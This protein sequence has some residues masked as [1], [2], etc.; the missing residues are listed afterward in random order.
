MPD[1]QAPNV[2]D[3]I[4]GAARRIVEV[5]RRAVPDAV[6]ERHA[7]A[8][9]PGAA[10]FEAALRGGRARR[11]IA[12]CKRR[13]P[14]RG[15]LRA[16]YDPVALARAYARAGAVAV[17]VLTEPT[18]FDGAPDH[19]RAVRGAVSLPLLRKDFVIDRYQL[20]EARSWGA[21]AVLLIVAALTQEEL[22]TL[23]REAGAL[24]LGALVEVHNGN[25]LERAID[26]GARMVGV[27]NRD[28]KTLGVDTGTSTRLVGRIPPGVLAVVES[29]I[30]SRDD[31]DRLMR[32]GYSAFL[33]GER[34]V[35]AAD[36][37][38]ALAELIR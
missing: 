4:V 12:E 7:A 35:T 5:R 31:L 36:P 11:V 15:V 21:D 32:E 30:E 22:G 13:S 24:G 9:S 6:L 26:G 38:A 29:G 8:Q 3:A 37:A 2:L 28:L 1:T 16:E 19:L 34:L 27:N 18:F 20:L 14:S 25:E 10:R 17:S 33:I 23:V